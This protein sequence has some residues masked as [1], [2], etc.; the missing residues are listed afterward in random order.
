MAG[1]FGFLTSFGKEKLGQAGQSITQR[2]VAWDPETASQAEIEEMI[3]ELDKI[4]VEAGK[5]K[6]EFDREQA[7]ADAARKNYER[8]MSA[9]ELLNKQLDEAKTAGDQT[10]SGQLGTSLEKL[11][12]DLEKLSPEVDREVREA[13]EA[14]A[15][16]DEVKELAELTAQKVKS[17]RAQ[18][19][20]AQRDMRRAEIEKERAKARAEKA[21]HLSGLRK[22]TSS[23]GVALAAMNRQA[24]NAKASASA[25]DMKAQLLAPTREKEDEHIKAALN[26]VSGESAPAS[27]SVADR[28]AALKKK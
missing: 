13:E 25:S 1:F 15:Y 19:E 7:E 21:E 16:Y 12:G 5:A 28:L 9:A 4:T 10:K 6:A 8:Y 14:K 17:A 2:I 18:L 20:G 23:L 24:E 27:S 3:A 22:D 26:A 11:L